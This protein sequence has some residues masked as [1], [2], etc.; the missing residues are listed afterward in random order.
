[1]QCEFFS[2]REEIFSE[3]FGDYKIYGDNYEGIEFKCRGKKIDF[4]LEHKT[5]KNKFKIIEL[6][7]TEGTRDVFGQISMYVGLLKEKFREKIE[8]SVDIIASS[9]NVELRDAVLAKA[10]EI[11]EPIERNEKKYPKLKDQIKKELGDDYKIPDDIEY[12]ITKKKAKNIPHIFKHKT[13]NKLLVAL[14]VYEDSG[15]CGFDS[16]GQ[17]FSCIWKHK[18]EAE[19][20]SGVII[21]KEPL[22]K[23]YLS[24]EGNEVMRKMDI[25]IGLWEYKRN[26]EKLT[27][28]KEN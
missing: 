14:F 3:Y 23:L 10:Y 8:I 19:E 5:E 28:K 2:Q 7:D 25:E 4:L 6:K 20:I 9:I 24:I 12:N 1:M 17:L 11:R 18:Y 27:L 21:G 15:E 16:F 13:K 26:E 22:D